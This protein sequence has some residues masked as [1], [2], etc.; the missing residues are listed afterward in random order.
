MAHEELEE[1]VL[2][3]LGG[4]AEVEDTWAFAS[5]RGIAHQTV[6]GV[7]K[8]LA[9]DNMVELVP[10]STNLLELTGEGREV[11]AL[12]SPE[13][14]VF[15][16]VPDG[17]ATQEQLVAALGKDMVKIGMGPLMK[18]KLLKKAGDSLSRAAASMV[19]ETAVLLRRVEE[20][21]GAVDAIPDADVKNLKKRQLV[22]TVVRKS[23]RVCRGPAFST[24]RKKRAADLTKE[25]LDSG[26]WA[27][28]AF[29]EY[30]FNTLGAPVVGGYFHPLLKVRAE[31][32]RILMNMGFEEMPTNRWVESSFWNFDALFQPQSHPARDA[33]DTFFVKDP[34]AALT[35]PEDYYD[36]VR[37]VHQEGG[38]GSVGYGYD[39]KRDEALKNILR[40]HTTAVSARMLY[41]LANQE[42]GFQPRKYF[43]I[44]RVFRNENMDATHLCEF[45]QVEGLVADR[46]LTLGD[47]IGTIRTF[48]ERI[49]ITDL[50]FKPAY[51]PYTEPSMEIFGYH[52]DLKKWTE[53]GNSGIFRP[54]MLRPMGLP[55]DVRVIA[56]GLSLERPTMIKYRIANIR[57][58]FGHKGSLERTRA[59]PICSF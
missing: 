20:G 58:L 42:G 39:F 27:T 45:H 21:R 26:E 31:F 23:F 37:S 51:N 8:S 55:E 9:A 50:K 6:V 12:G 52:P 29:K 35:V 40:T 49:G 47:L 54:E 5:D 44:D 11:L 1:T 16:A 19:D 38:Y 13:F 56:W 43:S 10:L 36:R 14:R 53:V 4:G 3:L 17:G 22:A 32:R 2:H 48:F 15:A 57:E 18:N 46:N 7:V 30:N 25:M 59:A 28:T 34:A 24:E 33:H 41:K